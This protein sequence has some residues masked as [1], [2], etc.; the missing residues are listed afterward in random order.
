MGK[1][2]IASW[3]FHL[4]ARSCNS[5]T[6]LL[7]TTPAAAAL[8]SLWSWKEETQYCGYYGITHTIS[9]FEA[10]PLVIL[11]HQ[12]ATRASSALPVSGAASAT[13]T[14]IKANEQAPAHPARPTGPPSPSRDPHPRE[15]LAR[16]CP[17]CSRA[18]EHL[19]AAPPPADAAKGAAPVPPNLHHGNCL[20]GSLAIFY[21]PHERHPKSHSTLRHVHAI[22]YPMSILY[23]DAVT[24][25]DN[26]S[27]LGC[28]GGDQKVPP[29]VATSRNCL[30]LWKHRRFF[31][32]KNWISMYQEE[33]PPAVTL[34]SGYS[35]Q[36]SRW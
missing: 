3:S 31:H 22:S 35:I 32:N 4:S 20:A 11:P 6:L 2:G 7:S 24:R 1:N 16:C 30:S 27:F 12:A 26:G 13:P 5:N 23:Q 28:C 10:R 21:L 17:P 15:A 34:K 25:E 19:P 33:V 14:P 18:G 29:S 9:D 36:C 8:S